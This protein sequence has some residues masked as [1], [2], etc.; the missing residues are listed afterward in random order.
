MLSLCHDTFN[1]L[2]LCKEVKLTSPSSELDLVPLKV[3]FVLDNFDETL[4]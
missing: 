1:V 3:G 4:E 2:N